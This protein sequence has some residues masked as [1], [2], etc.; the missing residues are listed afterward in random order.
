MNYK[1]SLTRINVLTLGAINGLI[2]GLALEKARLAYLNHQMTQAAREYA[3]TVFFA[4]FIEARWEPL[5]PLVSIA[6]F[7]VVAYVISECFLKRPGLLLLVWF[8]MG[9][10]AIAL[11]YFMSTSNPDIFSFLSL[12][13]LVGLVFLVYRFWKSHSNSLPLLWAI[14]GISAVFVVAVGVQLVGLFFYWPDLRKPFIWLICFAGVIATNIVFGAVVQVLFN[15]L[16]RRG[17]KEANAE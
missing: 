9:I 11:G 5:V 1:K 16:G 13:G 15:R 6:V 14:N 7:A 2:V 3:E 12:F 17:V 8:G 10:V 4:D